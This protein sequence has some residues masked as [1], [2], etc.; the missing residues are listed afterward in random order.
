MWVLNL[1]S[2]P[3]SQVSLEESRDLPDPEEQV[4]KLSLPHRPSPVWPLSGTLIHGPNIPGSYAILLFTALDFTSITSHIHN[5]AL[6]LLWLNLFIL[7]G[8][9]SPL[10]SSSIGYLLTWEVHLSMSYLFAFT[11]GSQGKSTE[12]V[13]HSLLQWTAFCQNS[14]PWPF[15]LWPYMAW[16]RVSVS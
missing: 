11:W 8:A 13:C 3:T 7:S 15:C 12:A 1:V 9:I 6:F 2:L 16:L 10:F 14:P 4:N 5:W